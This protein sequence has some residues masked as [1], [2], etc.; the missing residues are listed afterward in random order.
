MKARVLKKKKIKIVRNAVT[1]HGDTHL[2][3]PA[4]VHTLDAFDARVSSKGEKKK[5]CRR[6]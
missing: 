6:V 5:N 2:T 4:G 3:W 1:R